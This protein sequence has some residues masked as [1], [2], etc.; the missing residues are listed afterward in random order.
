V[1]TGSPA[2]TFGE[3]SVF[4]GTCMM[5]TS[6]GTV[7]AIAYKRLHPRMV[8]ALAAGSIGLFGGGLIAT[9]SE[10]R[11]GVGLG[12]AIL[13]G[14][15]ATG[16]SKGRKLC[17]D[18]GGA[19][20]LADQL[21][22]EQSEWAGVLMPP[23]SPEVDKLL[24]SV[25]LKDAGET[26]LRN[27]QKRWGGRFGGR[28]LTIASMGDDGSQTPANDS[29]PANPRRSIQFSAGESLTVQSDE[30]GGAS[31]LGRGISSTR[32]PASV[33]SPSPGSQS[34]AGDDF[35][36]PFSQPSDEGKEEATTEG[37]EALGGLMRG[38][39]ASLNNK[40]AADSASLRQPALPPR[41]RPAT[42]SNGGVG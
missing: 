9:Q 26:P 3:G 21:H 32:R 31:A 10:S 1:L 4:W 35:V 42:N 22:M 25:N 36:R 37:S 19:Q 11:I 33:D 17:C 34:T 23:D 14:C 7:F 20:T 12:M 30:V 29:L 5:L 13:I 39:E 38:L 8:I 16:V 6:F 28:G 27:K 15:C 41:K 24:P 2:V 40:W 18:C